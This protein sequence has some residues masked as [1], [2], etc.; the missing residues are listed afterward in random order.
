MKSF[1]LKNGK[2]VEVEREIK[3]LKVVSI[4]NTDYYKG[5]NHDAF[6]LTDGENQ[7]I[8]NGSLN[9]DMT[10]YDTKIA[11]ELCYAENKYVVISAYFVP[12]EST[13]GNE[14]FYI[15]NPRLLEVK[16]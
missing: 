12:M 15:Y 10:V 13:F 3:T 8:Y 7:Y 6:T 16:D 1:R 9:A 14:Y 11:Q 2:N 5:K 4:D